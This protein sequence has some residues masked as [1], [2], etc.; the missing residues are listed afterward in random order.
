MGR[1]R[2]Y[3]EEELEEKQKEWSLE[4]YHRNKKKI[5]KRA[6]KEYYARKKK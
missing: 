3:T 5:N 4:Y 6:M 1:K 2:K